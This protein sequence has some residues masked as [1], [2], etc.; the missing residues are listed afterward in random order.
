MP[1]NFIYLLENSRLFKAK[2]FRFK[3]NRTKIYLQCPYQEDMRHV[4]ICTYWNTEKEEIE[5]DMIFTDHI[6]H[7]VKFMIDLKKII[8][9]EKTI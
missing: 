5:Y 4:F 8:R 2:Q 3:C 9:K 6:S 1:R 7:L